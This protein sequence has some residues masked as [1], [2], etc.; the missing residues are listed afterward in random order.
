MILV[1][2][3]LWRGGEFAFRDSV[4]IGRMRKLIALVLGR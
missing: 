2:G 4:L 1:I 3:D